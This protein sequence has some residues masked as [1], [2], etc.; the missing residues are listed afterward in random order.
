MMIK[1]EEYYNNL[2]KRTKEYKEWRD[3]QEFELVENPKEVVGFTM[4]SEEFEQLPPEGLGDVIESITET[5]GI[6]KLIKAVWGDDC[7]CDERKAKLNAVL[8]F[9]VECLEESEYE[10]LKEFF[11]GKPNQVKPSEY[12]KL[13]TIARRIFNRNISDSMGCGGCVRDVVNRLRKVY[14]TYEND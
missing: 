12:K 9:K 3:A 6:K 10:Y 7:G 14:E 2:D 11:D 4:S 1:D 8:K 13:V 5:T